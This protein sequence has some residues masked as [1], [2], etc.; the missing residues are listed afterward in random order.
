MCLNGLSQLF[1]FTSHCI[2]KLRDGFF[3]FFSF[4][5]WADGCKNPLMSLYMLSLGWVTLF[6]QLCAATFGLILSPECN[7]V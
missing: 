7:N 4:F 6:K 2:Q 1:M 3:P 5:A